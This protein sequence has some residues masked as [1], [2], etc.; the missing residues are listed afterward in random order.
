MWILKQHVVWEDKLF[1]WICY[2]WNSKQIL[3]FLFSKSL[4]CS[5]TEQTHY[6]KDLFLQ[7]KNYKDFEFWKKILFCC[8]LNKSIEM[9]VLFQNSMP[10][11]YLSI[12]HLW[13]LLKFL[14]IISSFFYVVS[15]HYLGDTLFIL[16]KDR[17]TLISLKCHKKQF[18]LIYETLKP[19][20]IC[21]ISQHEVKTVMDLTFQKALH[22]TVIELVV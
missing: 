4:M 10:I 11:V 6:Q 21:F 15:L 16:W 9:N 8:Y 2:N 17:S 22:Q 1:F 13:H 3:V 14:L 7:T 18:E 19:N 5:Q 12:S 20:I